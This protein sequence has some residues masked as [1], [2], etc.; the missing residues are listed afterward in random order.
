MI[1]DVH[2][3]LIPESLLPALSESGVRLD[4]LRQGGGFETA[5]LYSIDRRLRDMDEQG[6]DMQVVSPAPGLTFFYNRE[7]D[8]ALRLCRQ[9]NDAFAD[10][11]A[12]N[13]KRFVAIA[14]LP[15]QAPE[16]AARELERAVRE[17]G[18]RGAEIYTSI[19]GKDLDDAGFAPLWAKAQELDVPLFLHPMGVPELGQRLGAY[20]LTNLVGNP[21]DTTIAAASLIFGGVLKEFPRLKVYL[22]HG[23]GAC[24]YVKGRWE[25]G[26]QVRDEARVKIDRPP[27]EYF[28]RLYFDS[29]VHDRG[30]LEFLVRSVGA[31][32]V[33]LGS[34][35]P[36]DM[37]A[38]KSVE[39][40]ESL[41]GFTRA[42]KDLVLGD[43]AARLFGIDS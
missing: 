8:E 38:Y 42:E 39:L 40:I 34:D 15:A 26:W 11:V 4:R 2:A 1:I 28:G 19:N 3:H 25:H 14:A 29:L 12:A 22:A 18:L 31:E 9:V 35:Y 6:V 16:L 32:R 17:R 24:P 43:N 30:A 20:Y 36:F 23:G 27:S 13:P 33:M 7:P 21:M 37:G 5:Q 41:G 10:V